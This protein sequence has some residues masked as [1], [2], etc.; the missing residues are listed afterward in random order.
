MP[1]L[2]SGAKPMGKSARPAGVAIESGFVDLTKGWTVIGN[3]PEDDGSVKAM[4]R[5]ASPFRN[6]RQLVLPIY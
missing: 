3:L 6:T 5:V 2:I 4:I 1:W